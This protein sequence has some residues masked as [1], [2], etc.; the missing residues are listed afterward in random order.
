[1][2]ASRPSPSIEEEE[3]PPPSKENF[4]TAAREKLLDDL[5]EELGVDRD[6]MLAKPRHEGKTDAKGAPVDGGK[7]R[8]DESDPFGRLSL[9]KE[10]TKKKK[11]QSNAFTIF[12][13]TKTGRTITLNVA[14]TDTIETVKEKVEDQEGIPSRRQHG[15]R[16]GCTN[17]Q[18]DRTL[19]SYNVKNGSSLRLRIA[20]PGGGKRLHQDMSVA[21]PFI[22][23]GPDGELGQMSRKR[24]LADHTNE[25]G[26]PSKKSKSLSS[27]ERPEG[28]AGDE[29]SNKENQGGELHHH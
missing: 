5:S 3:P 24:D 17:L 11:K 25:L 12:V 22:P 29:E 27:S 9:K 19:Q 4:D 7:R 14:D 26:S 10:E 20:A 15:Y 2:L 1:V 18:D 23:A 16:L 13:T 8:A 28:S 21:V 6:I